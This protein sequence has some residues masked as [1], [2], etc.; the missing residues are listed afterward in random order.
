F[1]KL[2]ERFC[3]SPPDFK[4]Q[5]LSLGENMNSHLSVSF[6]LAIVFAFPYILWELWR[7]I[8]PGLYDAER[9]AARGMVVI[10]SLLFAIG[11]LF[12]Y[13][14]LAPFSISFLA[15]YDIPETTTTTT[16]TSYTEYLTMLTL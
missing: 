1:C 11:V 2:G 16:L 8:A 13:F 5:N 10:C 14:V 4:V 7:F 3:F 12:G 9:K 15:G 6:L